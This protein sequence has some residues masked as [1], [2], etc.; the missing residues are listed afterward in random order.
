MIYSMTAFARVEKIYS[1]ASIQWELKS[2]NHRFLETQFRLPEALRDMETDLKALIRSGLSRGKL[3]CVLKL[4]T[5]EPGRIEINT[6]EL[7]Q[8]LRSIGRIRKASPHVAK[9]NALDILR[10][11][12]VISAS[13]KPGKKL[14]K[15]IKSTF[16]A[17]LEQLV[18]HRSREGEGLRSI[19]LK[20][21]DEV[22][23]LVL[24]ARGVMAGVGKAR[25][26]A[27]L[28]KISALD[29]SVNP[30]RLEQEVV[31]LVQR[32]DIMEEMDRLEIQ[33][34]ETCTAL[35]GA[36]PHGRRLDFLMQELNREANTLGS[37]SVLPKTT[38]ISVDL[39]VIIE[40][41]REQVQNIE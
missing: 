30:E 10:W 34:N 40:Q 22:S 29:L 13:S 24:E 23:T 17:T 26:A 19:L 6:A 36:G 33:V 15:A 25:H 9:P 18:E 5:I 27:L 1:Q 28:K 2:V 14:R 38:Q 31:M 20:K 3:D 41:I 11:P 32:A 7:E 35:K 37:K 21:L 8:V 12:G 39:K 16:Q 4:N